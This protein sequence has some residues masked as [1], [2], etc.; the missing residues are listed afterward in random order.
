MNLKDETIEIIRWNMKKT[1]NNTTF[2]IFQDHIKK[3]NKYISGILEEGVREIKQNSLWRNKCTD[4]R[5]T[6]IPSRI[7]V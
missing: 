2:V 6:V 5:K 7:N 4:S 3:M 1:K